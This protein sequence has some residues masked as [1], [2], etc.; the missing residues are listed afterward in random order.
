MVEG[1][2]KVNTKLVRRLHGVIRPFILRRLKS[3]VQLPLLLLLLLLLLLA[4][5][6]SHHAYAGSETTSKQIR[7]CYKVSFE[8]AAAP[9]MR[10]DCISSP[11]CCLIVML[12]NVHIA[13]Q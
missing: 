10:R 11:P 13:A 6:L 3:E 7:A 2:N 1:K 12:P 5:A 8:Q 9:G 4:R